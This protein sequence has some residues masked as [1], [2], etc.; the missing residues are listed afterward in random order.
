MVIFVKC[1]APGNS[2]P[3]AWH[4]CKI[5][6]LVFGFRLSLLFR[7]LVGHDI[8][9]YMQKGNIDMPAIRRAK[10]FAF[11][12]KDQS[13]ID[14][15]A[16][17]AFYFFMMFFPFLLFVVTLLRYV[18]LESSRFVQYVIT[19]APPTVGQ[20]IEQNVTELSNQQQSGLFSLGIIITLFAT[21]NSIH[22]TIR[23]INKTYGV[24]ETRSFFHIRGLTIVFALFALFIMIIQLTLPIFIVS[25]DEYVIQLYDIPRQS[26]FSWEVTLWVLTIASL[27]VISLILFRWAPNVS[28]TFRNVWIGALVTT[29]IIQIATWGLSFYVRNIGNFTFLHGSLSSVIILMIWFYLIGFSLLFGG[30]VNAFFHKKI[31]Q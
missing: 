9:D 4:F 14:D 30:H 12:L 8:K 29:F 24:E 27:Y 18:P 1:Q 25:I 22:A 16:Q 20:L 2:I 21:S 31:Q 6:I 26:I 7:G 17:L 10:S 3:G 23:S 19:Q 13:L 15:A 28:L 11:H 5:F